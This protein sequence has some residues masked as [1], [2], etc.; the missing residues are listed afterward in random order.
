[1][2]FLPLRDREYLISK[3]FQFDE[4]DFGGQ[5]AIRLTGIQLPTSKYDANQ[6][7]VLILLPAGYPDVLADM[8]YTF[9]W[10]KLLSTGRYPRAADQPLTFANVN[11]QRWSRHSGDWRPGRDGIWTLLTRIRHAVEVAE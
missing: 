9:P 8:F 11:W 1:M 4:L 7:D 3:G 10:I 2:S 6:V 5:K